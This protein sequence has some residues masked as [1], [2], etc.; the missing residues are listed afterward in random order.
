MFFRC[1]FRSVNSI[2]YSLKKK[3]TICVQFAAGN[4]FCAQGSE[5]DS[6]KYRVSSENRYDLRSARNLECSRHFRR[7]LK[8]EYVP[9]E[10]LVRGGR[11]R[12][13]SENVEAEQF[14]KATRETTTRRCPRA[15]GSWDPPPKGKREV[16]NFSAD[17]F[18]DKTRATDKRFWNFFTR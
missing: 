17:S 12:I 14:D 4:I 3:C 11:R 8:Y 1:K 16:E 18:R 9:C 6:E 15:V 2:K 7:V 13:T 10:L 5:S